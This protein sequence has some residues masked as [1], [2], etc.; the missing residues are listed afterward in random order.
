MALYV[1]IGVV[2]LSFVLAFFA[3]RTWHW[4]HVIV[5]IGIVLSTVGFVILAA[6]TLRINQVY[7]SAIARK[8]TELEQLTARNNALRDGT[9]DQAVINQ[10]R[11]ETEPEV[12]IP[13]NAESIPS[14]ADL[15][16][17]ILLATRA[18]G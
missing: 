12:A 6:E 14:L 17:E 13:E 18:R 9:E 7:R 16:H 1:L 15:D 3:A 4:G 8:T 11:N 5:A 10:L 2:L